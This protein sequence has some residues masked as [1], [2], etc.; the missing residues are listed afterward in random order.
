M[1]VA[2]RDE[3]AGVLTARFFNGPAE[4]CQLAEEQVPMIALNFDI[5]ILNGA[6]R[7]T[8]GFQLLS[9]CQ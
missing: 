7:P 5:A 4:L 2:C 3:K 1:A 9:K 6:A 8:A